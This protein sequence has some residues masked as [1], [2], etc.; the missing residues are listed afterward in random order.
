MRRSR[1]VLIVLGA[2][3]LVLLAAISVWMDRRM[4][5]VSVEALSG[6]VRVIGR[7][8][9]AALEA[10][11]DSVLP[12]DVAART[13]VKAMLSDLT[14]RSES[15]RALDVVAADGTIL[16]SDDRDAVGRTLEAA[17][18]A[19]KAG[20]ATRL[21]EPSSA[22]APE[23][24]YELYLPLRRDAEVAG[25][26]RMAIASESL[27]RI[28][29]QHRA[30]MALTAAIA[31]V[32]IIIVS[33]LLQDQFS[34]RGAAA[35]RAIEEIL[36]GRI[37]LPTV[38]HGPFARVFEEAGRLVE[39]LREEGGKVSASMANHVDRLTQLHAALAHELKAPLHAIVLNLELLERSLGRSTDAAR[40]NGVRYVHVI[41]QEI[42]RLERSVVALGAAERPGNAWEVI[43]LVEIVASVGELLRPRAQAENI[44]VELERNDDAPALVDGYRDS[45]KQAILNL[46]QNAIEAMPDGG[47]LALRV[48]AAG[49]DWCV[50]VED[51]GCGFAPEVLERL[52]R[53]PAT[54][55]ATGTGVG[56]YL[57]QAVVGAHG[58]RVDVTSRTGVG[59]LCEVILPRSREAA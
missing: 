35:A 48:R 54:T 39:R 9:V 51:D 58:G 37:T 53:S 11:G 56:L 6:S 42:G 38:R 8:I 32:G 43:D 4:R 44:A 26:L 16:A 14:E 12:L 1:S 21:I 52:E 23:A 41:K 40:A 17:D 2:V 49:D 15:V 13:R 5:S 18:R 33:V 30:Q 24:V 7:E 50:E 28:F 55:K 20:G 22:L 27:A 59:T 10:G 3:Y 19:L 31:L 34:R 57:A 29:A 36:T 45:L 46:A 25:Y 47:R